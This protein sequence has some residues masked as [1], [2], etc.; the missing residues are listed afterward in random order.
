MI[1]IPDDFTQIRLDLARPDT[2]ETIGYI[3]YC[4]GWLGFVPVTTDE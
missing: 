2:D 3:T 4:D 1:R